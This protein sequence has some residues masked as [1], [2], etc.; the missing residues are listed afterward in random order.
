[1]NTARLLSGAAIVALLFGC[2]SHERPLVE[3]ATPAAAAP[4]PDTPVVTTSAPAGDV[5]PCSLVSAQDMGVMFGELKEGPVTSTG[6]RNERQCN[7]TNMAGSWIKLSVYSGKERWEWERGITN[8]QSPRDVGGLGDEAFAIKRG[9]DAVVYVR[10]GDRILELSCS[11]PAETA[12][13]I[14]RVATQRL[15]EK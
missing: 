6:L 1:M 12:E 14:A 9:T 11:C 3:A 5:D 13:A 4:A 8:A 15:Q 2:E 7:F 10:K